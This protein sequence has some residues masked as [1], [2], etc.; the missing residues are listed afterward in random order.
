MEE[1]SGSLGQ[2]V[3]FFLIDVGS[4]FTAY[5]VFILLS[6]RLEDFEEA[7]N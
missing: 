6:F 4:D 7:A 3:S 2:C 5:V 1:T